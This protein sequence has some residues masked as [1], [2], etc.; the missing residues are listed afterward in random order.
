MV[1]SVEN[2]TETKNTKKWQKS[3][4]TCLFSFE[5]WSKYTE[6]TGGLNAFSHFMIP[7][8]E[9]L[10]IYLTFLPDNVLDVF[11]GQTKKMPKVALIM[12]IFP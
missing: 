5:N 4:K 12:G 9:V 6:A 8:L 10:E 3:G 11:A 2:E 1:R 7:W